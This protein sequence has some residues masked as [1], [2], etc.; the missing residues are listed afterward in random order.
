MLDYEII[1]PIPGPD[2]P[3]LGPGVSTTGWFRTVTDPDGNS[4]PESTEQLRET[5]APKDLFVLAAPSAQLAGTEGQ[6]AYHLKTAS[7][8]YDIYQHEAGAWALKIG[9]IAITTAS[10]TNNAAPTITLTVSAAS[11][12]L[13]GAVTLT[14]N[15]FDSD[16][17]ISKVE[18]YEGGQLIT[19]KSSAPYLLDVTPNS[20]GSKQYTGVA[21]DNLNL[22]R[23][24]AP[25]KVEVFGATNQAPVVG[26]SLSTS[27]VAAGQSMTITVTATDADGSIANV[28]V[29][30]SGRLLETFTEAPYSLTFATGNVGSHSIIA[31]ATDNQGATRTSEAKVL[32][33]TA[34]SGNQPP[35][36]SYSQSVNTVQVGQVVTLSA[37]A[38]DSDGNVTKVEFF[39]GG[40]KVGEA[41]T[42]PYSYQFAP[43]T[44]GTFTMFAKATD[45]SGNTATTGGMTL[46]VT[47]TPVSNVT[48]A[49]PTFSGFSDTQAG[50]T[51]TLDVVAPYSLS[52]YRVSLPGTPTSFNTPSSATISVGNVAGPIRAYIAAATGR[53]QSQ[54]ATSTAFTV[55]TPPVVVSYNTTLNGPSDAA[56]VVTLSSKPGVVVEFNAPLPDGDPGPFTTYLFVGSEEIGQLDSAPGAAGQP[57]RLTYNGQ[58]YTKTFTNG[59]LN[60]S[61]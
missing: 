5:I 7:N 25:V 20:V 60:L 26:V 15:P 55:Y 13:G 38:T 44:A 31:V 61:A 33:V 41:L 51:V 42:S 21:Y 4:S 53:N 59:N 37:S 58:S 28:K 12:S 22:S 45:N 6:K 35:Q 14:A 17:T 24:S 30:D 52:D 16:G 34:T 40:T 49:T 48:P 39:Q 10:P 11:V 57:F 3:A 27:T 54:T 1:A 50:G 23:T 47:T 2:F 29:Y 56:D 32:T 18:F 46:T 43:T 36:V 19:T 8:N 9:G